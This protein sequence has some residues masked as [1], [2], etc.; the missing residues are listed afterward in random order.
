MRYYESAQKK[1]PSHIDL[2]DEMAQ[3]AYKAREFDRAEQIYQ[4]NSATK[5]NQRKKSDAYH[6]L[7]NSRMKKKDFAGAIEAY[8]E[9]LR[10]DPSNKETRYNLS[11]AI[12]KQREEQKKKDQDKNQDKDK[13]QENQDQCKNPENKGDQGR[14]QKNN[15][16]DNKS[17]N[18]PQ[19]QNSSEKDQQGGQKDGQLPNKS[20]ERMLDE[21]MK[22]E[23][24]TKRKIGGQKGSGTRNRSGKD[25]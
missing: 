4:Q 20:V 18:K 8:K 21:L 1:A 14:N 25:W 19:H 16:S 23:S 9:S 3:S 6:N 24:E 5:S 15:T 2:S 17:S 13:E 12:R 11:E 7:G 22:A 10:N